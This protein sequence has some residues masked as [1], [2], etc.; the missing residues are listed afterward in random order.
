MQDWIS[1][2]RHKRFTYMYA[3]YRDY[4]TQYNLLDD[5]LVVTE[6][7]VVVVTENKKR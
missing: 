2:F 4:E 3:S 6:E 5:V 7:L 1:H